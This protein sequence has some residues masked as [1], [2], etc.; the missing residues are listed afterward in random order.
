MGENKKKKKLEKFTEKGLI[1]P[2]KRCVLGAQDP[3]VAP[4]P[5]RGPHTRLLTRSASLTIDSYSAVD[6]ADLISVVRLDYL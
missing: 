6:Y 4:H 1:K 3:R 5:T 2:T